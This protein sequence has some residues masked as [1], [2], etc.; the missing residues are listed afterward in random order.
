MAITNKNPAANS[1]IGPADSF[2]F[3]IDHTYT[4]LVVKVTQS[5]GDEYAYDSTLGGAQAG[6]VVTIE[7]S[8][9][10]ERVTVTRTAGWE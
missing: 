5:G 3:D 7:D 8:G 1:V 2:S 4:S 9:M 10:H 6:Y